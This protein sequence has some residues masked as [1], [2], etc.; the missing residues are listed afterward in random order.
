MPL[1][2]Q[3]KYKRFAPIVFLIKAPKNFAD[4]PAIG[5]LVLPV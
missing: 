2:K 1:D 4:F 3:K 5:H